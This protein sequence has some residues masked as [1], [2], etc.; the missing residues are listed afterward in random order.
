[1]SNGLLQR[2]PRRNP[3]LHQL[4]KKQPLLTKRHKNEEYQPAKEKIL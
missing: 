4:P 3:K 2:S 1:M